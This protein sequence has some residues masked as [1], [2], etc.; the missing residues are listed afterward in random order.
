M[1]IQVPLSFHLHQSFIFYSSC[2]LCFRVF[3]LSSAIFTSIML[4]NDHNCSSWGWKKEIFFIC[5]ANIF[6][7]Q[8]ALEGR[9]IDW[10]FNYVYLFF[11]YQ[12]A[13]KKVISAYG[14]YRKE[15]VCLFM[16]FY[17]LS[18]IFWK[19]AKGNGKI[20]F[21]VFAYI[22]KIWACKHIWNNIFSDWSSEIK[23]GILVK[24]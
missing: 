16:L 11:S 8:N 15:I 24:V 20:S 5:L 13:N 12:R 14:F 9:V 10:I 3:F 1:N 23:H 7:R 17:Y 19:V 6:I 2:N 18:K 4:I 21:N 22:Y